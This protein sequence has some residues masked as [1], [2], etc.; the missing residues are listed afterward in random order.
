MGRDCP[1]FRQRAVPEVPRETL[2][3]S[4]YSGT[5]QAMGTMLSWAAGVCSAAGGGG[6]GGRD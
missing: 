1:S 3:A 5:P 6:G 2:P 4:P